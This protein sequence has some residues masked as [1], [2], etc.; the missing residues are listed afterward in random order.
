MDILEPEWYKEK[1]R[2]KI[3]IWYVI[4]I[5]YSYSKSP[6][7]IYKNSKV[8]IICNWLTNLLVVSIPL[9][10]MDFSITI[11]VAKVR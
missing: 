1:K 4:I 8:L 7:L 2:N 3:N 9:I 5:I 6:Y 11:S 10:S